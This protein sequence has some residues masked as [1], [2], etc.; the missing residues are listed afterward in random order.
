MNFIRL[1]RRD[2]IWY[3]KPFAALSAAA[4]LICAVLTS[5]LLI[6]E[7]VRGT[8]NDNLRKDTAFV[9]T[10]LR[11]ST[12]VNIDTSGGVLHTAGFISG[13][14]R[15]HLYAFPRE[16][17]IHGRDA[18]CSKA[19]TEALKLNI[20]DTFTV[21]VQTIAAIKSEELMGIPPRLK[22]I[23]FIYKG[24]WNNKKADVNFENPQLRPNNLFVSHAFLAQE[25]GLKANAVNEIWS[26]K[27]LAEVRKELSDAV[28][29]DLSQLAFER[30]QNRPILK[31]KS[32]YLPQKAVKACPNALKG[33]ISF[34]ESL[35]DSKN[36]LNYFFVG[37]F[38]G[39]ILPVKSGCVEISSELREKF[40]AP[41]S[42]TCFMTDGYRRIERKTQEFSAVSTVPDSMISSIL[43]PDIPGLT[44]VSDCTR[45]IS[46]LPINLKRIK[47]EDKDY[48]ERYKSKPKIYLNFSQ[49]QELFAPGK[50]TLLVFDTN[51]DIAGIKK[52]IV[53]ELRD[54]PVL[55]HSMPVAEIMEKNIR[56]GIQFAPLFLGLSLFIIISGLLILLMLLK[57]H[58]FDRSAERQTLAE[59]VACENKIR[60]FYLMELLT[61]LLP[62]ILLGL[63]L[64][65]C[66]CVL[67]LRLL[68]HVWNGIIL[69]K[70]LN[71]H[72]SPTAFII[73]FA[74]TF[75]SALAILAVS[76]R[77][78][79]RK[80]RFYIPGSRAIQSLC[81][82][83]TLSFFRRFRQYGLCVIL[84]L[85][86]IIGTLGVGAF[87]IKVRGE[88]GF[89]Y[90][91]IAE[92]ALPVVP[93][94]DAPFPAG[95][96]PV[97]V[98][99][100]DSA[101]CSNLLQ[102]SEPT[103]YGCNLEK[104][105]GK[106][107]FL[108]KFC[109]AVDVGSMQWIMKKKLGDII[110]YPNGSV[111]LERTLKA[112]VFQSGILVDNSTFE[113]LFPNVQGAQ[114]FLI[115]DIKSAEAYRTYLKPFG[116][117]MSTV[118]SFM[119]KAESVQNRYLAIFLQL[120]VLGFI[121]GIGSL[122]LLMVRNLH[123]RRGEIKFLS[124]SGFTGTALFRLYCIE[125]LWIYG[126]AAVV[127]LF[128]LGGLAFFASL[129]LSI[130]LY[131]WC[132][133]VFLGIGMICL[134][135]KVFFRR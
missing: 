114:F 126:L 82:L 54:D 49:A 96:L 130:L 80:P 38:E 99:N 90:E 127:S 92:T 52:R 2:I 41:L 133:L 42:L 53:S 61:I 33:L 74:A 40:M 107:N 55:F 120:G 79:V 29:W 66:L 97:R 134:T 24:V 129:N 48:W 4:C 78:P 124:E 72:A 86:G 109:A 27:K 95:G 94:F 131:R 106:Q 88:D 6:G 12:P 128:I 110:H 132:L 11:F 123:A 44:D 19:L 31:S 62:G 115:R 50:C 87:G 113:D 20:G 21:R 37:A 121:L 85:L 65:T 69:I 51:A 135:L 68:E 34:A 5:A 63:L 45:W 23:R 13:G 76:L 122:L 16:N 59:F 30:W 111:A 46:G 14:F 47:D 43:T 98:Y 60:R 118:D 117:T 83:G 26:D 8:L 105:T 75:C 7:S 71:F 56:N 58:L 119:A 18:Y 35:S 89:S 67:Q 3:I 125:N 32:Y 73:A 36:T 100:A 57:L 101:D 102:A 1:F 91:Y 84:L 28:I 15:T 93:S 81:A 17:A 10:L 22:Q 108:K 9:K 77:M 39:D 112:S 103:V 70:R 64:G 104:L 25:L 116:L